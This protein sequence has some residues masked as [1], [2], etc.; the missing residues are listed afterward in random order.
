MQLK[1]LKVVKANKSVRLRNLKGVKQFLAEARSRVT[2][3][4]TLLNK[5]QALC[6]KVIKETGCVVSGTDSEYIPSLRTNFEIA[7]SYTSELEMLDSILFQMDH[8]FKTEASRSTVIRASQR[9]RGDI[10]NKL[11]RVYKFI[12][13]IAADSQPAA[14]REIA[15]ELTNKF[16]DSIPQNRYK[17]FTN[18]VL[19]RTLLHEQHANLEFTHYIRIQEFK[20]DNYVYDD[21]YIVL[22]G[23]TGNNNRLDLYLTTLPKFTAPGKFERGREVSDIQETLSALHNLLEADKITDILHSMTSY[24]KSVCNSD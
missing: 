7:A 11:E 9:L 17:N 20:A 2:K 24:S 15:R 4:Q 16:K 22:T 14:F 8:S 21:Y 19:V 10:A 13:S 6:A 12:A 18:Q 5:H 3:Y 23:V 1:E